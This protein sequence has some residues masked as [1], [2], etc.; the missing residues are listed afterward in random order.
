MKFCSLGT[1]VFSFM[2][3]AYGSVG[4][5]LE[6]CF[7]VLSRDGTPAITLVSSHSLLG[8]VKGPVGGRPC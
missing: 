6:G 8:Y 2:L 5:D 1:F 3:S 4:N 7:P